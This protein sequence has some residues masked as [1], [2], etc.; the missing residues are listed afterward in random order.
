MNFNGRSIVSLPGIESFLHRVAFTREARNKY[1]ALEKEAKKLY[2]E[3]AE[4]AEREAESG[5][6]SYSNILVALTRLRWVRSR[7][8]G[9]RKEERVG[10]EIL[11]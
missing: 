5:V 1:R 2:R 10:D 8:T 4:K 7:E 6:K 3:Y 11:K 9:E